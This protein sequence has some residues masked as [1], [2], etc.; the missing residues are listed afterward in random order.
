MVEEKRGR[1][2]KEVIEE[3]EDKTLNNDYEKKEHTSL[4]HPWDTLADMA[5]EVKRCEEVVAKMNA[6]NDQISDDDMSYGEAGGND[7]SQDKA[8]STLSQQDLNATK[9]ANDV[10][11]KMIAIAN[12]SCN[13]CDHIWLLKP[14]Q[15]K[16]KKKKNSTAFYKGIDGRT[17]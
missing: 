9:I 11:S 7:I 6:D 17:Y 16:I 2:G 15:S 4:Q 12:Y 8:S 13:K 1:E 5:K 3:E 14:K 10:V